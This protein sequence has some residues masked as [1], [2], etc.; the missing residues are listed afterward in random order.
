MR[1]SGCETP[2]TGVDKVDWDGV[3]KV[4]WD[5]V[6]KVDWDGVDKVDRVDRVDAS[7][8]PQTD[9]YPTKMN[10]C[11]IRPLQGSQPVPHQNVDATHSNC[12]ST[13]TNRSSTHENVNLQ[14]MPEKAGK[15]R[16]KPEICRKASCQLSQLNAAINGPV[17][18]TDFVAVT[19]RMVELT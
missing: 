12:S 10:Q 13:P 2:Q 8:S 6:D 3:D 15:Y 16:T 7:L 11:N 9:Q 17:Y 14:K 19:Q 4:D 5:G 1:D 18:S